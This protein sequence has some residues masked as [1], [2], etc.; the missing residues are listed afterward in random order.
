M[1]RHRRAQ[2]AQMVLVAALRARFLPQMMQ[3][4]PPCAWGQPPL[5]P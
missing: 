1:C 4:K 5:S 2:P 3:L